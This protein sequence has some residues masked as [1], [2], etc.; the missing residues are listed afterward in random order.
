[1]PGQPGTKSET[2]VSVDR[3]SPGNGGMPSVHLRC[4]TFP[5]KDAPGGGGHETVVWFPGSTGTKGS[6]EAHNVSARGSYRSNFV[7]QS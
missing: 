1:M 2:A 7:N 3:G 6:L 5:P 4:G